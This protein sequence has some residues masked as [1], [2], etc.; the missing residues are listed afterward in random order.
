M[1]FTLCSATSTNMEEK[2]ENELTTIQNQMQ[3]LLAYISSR[4]DIPEH[5]ASMATAW[6]IPR[7]VRSNLIVYLRNYISFL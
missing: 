4:D 5:F 6:Y 2:I 7:L 1:N 3:T